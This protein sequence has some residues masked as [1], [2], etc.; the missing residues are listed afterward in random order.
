M[1]SLSE[2]VYIEKVDEIVNSTTIHIT[3]QSNEVC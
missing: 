1:T 3:A 2:H